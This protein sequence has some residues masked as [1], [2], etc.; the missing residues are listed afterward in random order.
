MAALAT[1]SRIG[2]YLLIR[3]IG[4]GAMATVYEANHVGL[5]KH[6]ALKK[7][8]PHLAV[9]TVAA[10]RFL[11]EGKAAAHIKSPH[12]VDVFDVGTHDGVP[13]LVMELLDG[14]DLSVL[15]RERGKLPLPELADLMLPIASAVQAAHEVGVIHRDLKPSNI[16]LA[17]RTGANV[18]PTVL[19]FGISMVTGDVDRDLTGSEVLLGTVHYMSPEQTRGG[20]NA[21]AQSDQYSLGVLLYECSTGVKPFAGGSPYG[22]MHAIVSAKP[23]APSTLNPKLPRAFD[24]VVLRA[25]HRDPAKRFPS[26]GSLGAAL[27]T[28]ASEAARE[29]WAGE[30]GGAT[31]AAASRADRQRRLGWLAASVVGV[32][33]LVVALM[34]AARARPSPRPAPSDVAAPSESGGFPPAA[35]RSPPSSPSPVTAVTEV[36]DMSAAPQAVTTPTTSATAPPTTPPTAAATNGRAPRPRASSSAAPSLPRA[37]PERGTNGALIVE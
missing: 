20:R 12:V 32:G 14:V 22:V 6:V 8:H 15:L 11:R 25:M 35:D 26:V 21:S 23:P 37:Q 10:S 24:E 29:R 5:G 2:Q 34:V 31:S 1:G 30:F 17:R 19:D 9:D 33:V 28:W 16:V 3:E 36:P 4:K 7:M 13:Y 18:S 27:L